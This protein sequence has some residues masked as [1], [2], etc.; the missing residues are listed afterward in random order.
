MGALH[1]REVD[2]GCDYFLHAGG[3]SAH[4]QK[5]EARAAH[6]LH[7]AC[8]MCAALAVSLT[9]DLPNGDGTG[10]GLEGAATVSEEQVGCRGAG[11]V[12]SGWCNQALNRLGCD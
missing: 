7:C 10:E 6:K 1:Y 5:P 8:A 2:N 12:A 4:L 11:A 3:L 9:R